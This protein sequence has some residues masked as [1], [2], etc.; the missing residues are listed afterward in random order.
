MTDYNRRKEQELEARRLELEAK[1]LEIQEKK[2][3][4]LADQQLD[5]QLN[6][7][8]GQVTPPSSSAP[9]IN[10]QQMNQA[11]PPGTQARKNKV[12]AAL[13][14][15]FLGPLGIHKFYLNRGGAGILMLLLT[16]SL[17]GAIITVPLALIECIIYL[18]Q[19]DESFHEKYVVG[20]ASWF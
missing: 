5:Q 4:M 14:A 12:V 9:T 8:S 7:A 6:A 11:T 15:F 1:R 2:L 20:K 13:L 18:V 17:I 19:S 16:V 10:I 3:Q